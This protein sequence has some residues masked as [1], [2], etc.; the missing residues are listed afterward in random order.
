MLPKSNYLNFLKLNEKKL[1]TTDV[2]VVVAFYKFFEVPNTL[3]LQNSLRLILS[4]T[5][6]KGTIL[7]AKEGINGTI[8]GKKEEVTLALEKIWD[9]DFLIDLEPK[10]SFAYKNPFFRMKI[11]QKKEIVTIGLPEIS[12]NKSVGKYIKPENWNDLISDKDLLLIDTRNSYEVSIG[13]FENSLNPK[14]NSFRE[15]PDWVTK[16]LINKD[17][18]IKNK[19][20]AMFCT[21]GIRC[22]KS[23][24]YLKS[25]GFD[26]V[27]HLEGGILKYLEKIPKNESK[28]KGSCFV[29]DYR[30]SVDHNL[31]LGHYEMCFACRMPISSTDKMHKYFVQ[32][33]SCHHCFKSSNEKQKKRFKERQKQIEISR[34]KDQFH[35]GQTKN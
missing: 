29:F 25:I 19:K 30:V 20:V 12:P 16:N 22:E 11:R 24:S 10:Y 17:P 7:I 32:G 3:E 23:T 15:F 18:E 31:E 6:I 8:A 28:W 13:S 4:K 5:E 9:L 21:G 26:K 1:N 2:K 34:K 35:I 27:Y 33:E 14:I